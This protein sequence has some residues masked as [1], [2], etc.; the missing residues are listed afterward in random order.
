MPSTKSPAENPGT[1]TEKY[2]GF[3]AEERA[4]MQEHAPSQVPWG[5]AAQRRSGT[6]RA[7]RSLTRL[8]DLGLGG[9]GGKERGH[10]GGCTEP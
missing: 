4:A 7:C 5:G 9:V 2:D 3:T 10:V 8:F 1:A 6:F